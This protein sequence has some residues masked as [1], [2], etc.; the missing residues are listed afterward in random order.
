[1][2]ENKENKHENLSS[3]SEVFDKY[4]KYFIAL[5]TMI[6]IFIV[7][8]FLTSFNVLPIWAVDIVLI[9]IAIIAIAVWYKVKKS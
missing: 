6:A 9:P 2:Q 5:F 8:F 3:K 1:M 7:S 4:K